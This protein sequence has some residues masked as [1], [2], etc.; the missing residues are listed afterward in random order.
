MPE[1]VRRGLGRNASVP[2][3]I[4]V[5]LATDLNQYV[6]GGVARNPITPAKVLATLA[7]DLHWYVRQG[8]GKEKSLQT[9][10]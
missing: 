4:L 3:S 10:G 1:E 9:M 8:A 7:A 6:R 2:T 5:S